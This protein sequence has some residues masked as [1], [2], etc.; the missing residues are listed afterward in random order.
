MKRA[1]LFTLLAAPMLL[2]ESIGGPWQGKVTV[3]GSQVPFRFELSGDGSNV[4]G[5]FFNGDERFISTSGSYSNHSL[6][7][8]WDYFAAKL[9]AKVDGDAIEGTYDR[10]RGKPIAFH[11][12]RGPAKPALDKGPVIDGLWIIEDVASK[13]GESAWHFIVKQK[14]TEVSAAILRV[15]GD[16]GTLSGSYDGEAGKFVLGHFSGLRP[17]RLEITVNKDGSLKL[18]EGNQT[19]TAIRVAEVRAR[20]LPVPTDPTRHTGV[21]DPSEPFHFSFADLQGRTVS[22]TDPRFKNKV[23]LVNI[24]GS[25]CPNCH[26]EA[27]FLEET[28]RKFRGRG[29]EIVALS[30]EEA[31]QLKDP[32]RLRAFIQH[33]GID[34]TVLLCGTTDEAKEKLSQ[35]TNWDSWPT[36]FFI[37]R[38][39]LVRAVHA[40]FPSKASGELYTKAKEEFTEQVEHL[41]T[42]NALTLRK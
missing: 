19:M 21:K 29:L 6:E 8:K 26:D 16:T 20:Q 10:A 17:A 12:T 37:G 11:A 24:T 33:Y 22:D 18:V 30:F 14:P 40:G 39:G 41:L 13:K 2:A 32:T 23:V 25:W 36:T 34:Y 7:L 27:P 35:A 28:Y 9:T 31:D 3:D 42:E 5:T 38:N 1:A 4:K 15:D